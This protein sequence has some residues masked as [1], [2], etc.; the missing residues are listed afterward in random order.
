MKKEKGYHKLIVW[1]KA[2]ELVKL[3]YKVTTKLP[4]NEDFILIS[5][6]RRAAISI[7]ANIVEGHA[8]SQRSNKD[9]LNFLSMAE[10]SLVELEALLEIAIDLY[11]NLE[12]DFIGLEQ[13][14][15]EVAFLLYK[16]I[17]A[18]KRRV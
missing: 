3:T 4:K 14:R 12:K 8:R 15:G 11:P 10:G 17:S 16:F 7:V 6:I 18:V 2:K 9:F 5:Q 1:Q 13:S